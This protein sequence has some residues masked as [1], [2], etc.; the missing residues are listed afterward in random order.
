MG[1][2]RSCCMFPHSRRLQEEA[3]QPKQAD[4]LMFSLPQSLPSC[5]ALPGTTDSPC[6]TLGRS[7]MHVFSY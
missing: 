3:T 4:E 1:D 2:A 5:M 6:M 7:A